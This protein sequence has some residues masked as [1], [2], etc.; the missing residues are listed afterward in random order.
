VLLVSDPKVGVESI[1]ADGKRIA[2]LL[3]GGKLDSPQIS[4]GG[5]KAFGWT[6]QPG[7]SG[8]ERTLVMLNTTT[9]TMYPVPLFGA[10][11]DYSV[12]WRRGERSPFIELHH[13]DGAWSVVNP[14]D[15][16]TL[17]RVVTRAMQPYTGPN[18]P[19]ISPAGA[20]LVA[21]AA[22]P[23]SYT[24]VD[25]T[26]GAHIT[27][28]SDIP[29]SFAPAKDGGRERVVF[30]MPG[31]VR[32]AGDPRQP[33]LA[34]AWTGNDTAWDSSYGQMG[35]SPNTELVTFR[36][37][38][39]RTAWVA[40]SSNLARHSDTYVGIGTP[41][42]C[43]WVNGHEVW[44]DDTLDSKEDSI[45]IT[46]GIKRKGAVP[47][48]DR[49]WRPGPSDAV[50]EAD[51]FG[52]AQA[53]E[54]NGSGID[55]NGNVVGIGKF[56]F[57]TGYYWGAGSSTASE[58]TSSD[59]GA[60]DEFLP[61]DLGKDGTVV[62]NASVGDDWTPYA[63][64]SHKGFVLL[65]KTQLDLESPVVMDD[66]S[67][68]LEGKVWKPWSIPSSQKLEG[69][70]V[71]PAAE[72]LSADGAHILAASRNGTV[73]GVTRT[74][75]GWNLVVGKLGSKPHI[76]SSV[77]FQ[78]VV[79]DRGPWP[80][81]GGITSHDLFVNDKGQVAWMRHGGREFTFERY[82]PTSGVQR[83]AQIPSSKAFF[84]RG[85]TEWG[86]LYGSM[87]GEGAITNG[88][89]VITAD[90]FLPKGI[91]CHD[92]RKI[93]RAGR[94]VGPFFRNGAAVIMSVD[95]RSLLGAE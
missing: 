80:T 22:K 82:D 61:F 27:F 19:T 88:G 38:T 33:Q 85:M 5:Q 87:D 11:G 13:A 72:D 69:I 66:G 91:Q 20:W 95:V 83:L 40:D 37:P 47:L 4:P 32:R 44:Y 52:L 25:L 29:P 73:A 76:V 16:G 51:L 77:S 65:P 14:S 75:N 71:G 79:L 1:G 10:S 30:M 60:D 39:S 43:G 54:Y 48:E 94:A 68:F 90:M 24:A 56:G 93:S 49:D 46:L 53:G 55:E 41:Y 59:A 81:D 2:V 26:T 23:G 8:P 86:E 35:V 3:P 58:V 7:K 50:A 62:G 31:D 70:P 57:M 42:S 18:K 64:N 28:A 84:I 15:A 21:A 12:E 67:I 34:E 36:E 92:I 78:T 89:Q 9:G 17:M 45:I 63:W 74:D 6:D